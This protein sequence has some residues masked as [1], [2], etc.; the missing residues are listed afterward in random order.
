MMVVH[1]Q[2]PRCLLTD[3]VDV[4]KNTADGSAKGQGPWGQTNNILVEI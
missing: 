3:G 2:M 4:V 1:Q